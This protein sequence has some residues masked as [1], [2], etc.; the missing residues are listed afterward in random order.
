MD[1]NELKPGDWVIFPNENKPCR[2]QEIN[3]QFVDG[4]YCGRCYLKDLEPVLLTEEILLKNGWITSIGLD[5]NFLP[6]NK[7]CKYGLRLDEYTDGVFSVDYG[8]LRTKITYVHELQHLL[9]VFNKG[10]IEL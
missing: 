5:Y 10:D 4:L 1:V 7:F 2:I 9:W 3:S 8:N 6:Y